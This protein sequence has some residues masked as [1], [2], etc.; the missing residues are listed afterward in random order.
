MKRPILLFA[1]ILGFVLCG[2]TDVP[3][4]E[5]HPP[6][7]D[8]ILKRGRL[9]VL[10]DREE[11]F[12]T[13]LIDAAG[14]PYGLDLDL[15]RDVANKLGVALELVRT[16]ASGDEKVERVARREAD[17]AMALGITPERAR[18]VLFTR[19]YL[20][21]HYALVVNRI[22]DARLGGDADASLRSGKSRL[23]ILRGSVYAALAKQ[24]FPRAR[25]FLCSH[26][27]VCQRAVLE[28]RVHAWLTE[29]FETIYRF[30]RHPE[31]AVKLKTILLRDH[32]LSGGIA[33]PWDSLHFH[34]WLNLYLEL[35]GHD[36]TAAALTRRYLPGNRRP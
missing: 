6:D 9:I 25:P 1:L 36:P 22:L 20:S 21:E 16:D 12:P 35:S 3:A 8:R 11:A 13:T 28:G 24:L 30:S 19:P 17:M 32:P 5:T 18:K 14:T 4:G 31:H 15:A 33:V 34:A 29:E 10:V 7:I 26:R 23:A 2:S 27:D